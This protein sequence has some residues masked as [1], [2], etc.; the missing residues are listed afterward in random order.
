MKI[1]SRICIFLLV[2]MGSGCATNDTYLKRIFN[3]KDINLESG[4]KPPNMERLQEIDLANF[5]NKGS[6]DIDEAMREFRIR[7]GDH[8]CKSERNSIQDRLITASNSICR[9]YKSEL[10]Q[11]HADTNLNFGGAS[12]VLGGLGAVVQSVNPARYFSGAAS[13]ASGLRAEVNQN[14]Y[15]MLA[16]EVITKAIDKGRAD[17]LKEIDANQSRVTANYTLERAIADAVE[18]HSRCSLLAGLQEASNAVSQSENIGI[19]ALGQTLTDLGQTTS[20]QLGKKNYN[21]FGSDTLFL[22]TNCKSANARYE[23]FVKEKNI[24]A[25]KKDC[26]SFRTGWENMFKDASYCKNLDQ[27]GDAAAAF[28]KKWQDLINEFTNQTDEKERERVMSLIAAQQT[29]AKAIAG[30]L[31][32]FLDTS[33]NN[34]QSAKN[35]LDSASAAV[36]KMK[37]MMI[38]SPLT[39]TST[40]ASIGD[41]LKLLQDLQSA[42]NDALDKI[43]ATKSDPDAGQK[44][45]LVKAIDTINKVKGSNDY[46]AINDTIVVL[47][48]AIPA[49]NWS[50]Q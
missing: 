30:A 29:G 25:C 24:D 11:A 36:E 34:M 39:N 28:D 32:S 3:P 27:D 37:S 35:R 26:A 6:K 10:K 42:A 13:I 49:F 12:T 40:Q 50:P 2:L 23:N 47:N 45:S 7:C 5:I 14:I 15:A 38:P 43:K 48:A 1:L 9:D 33:I 8:D 41:A 22:K 44:D 18:Y 16:V 46:Q 17:V 19:K 21:L 20:I 31:N 4:K